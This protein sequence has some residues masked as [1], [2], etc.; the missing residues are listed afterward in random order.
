MHPELLQPYIEL[1]RRYLCGE[2]EALGFE[3]AYLDLYLGSTTMWEDAY[4][5]ILQQLFYAVEDFCADDML[6]K[7][8]DVTESELRAACELALGKLKSMCSGSE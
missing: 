8:G 1:I 3:R 4:Y 6:R 7:D 5:E 2:I